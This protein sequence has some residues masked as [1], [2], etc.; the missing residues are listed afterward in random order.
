MGSKYRDTCYET[1]TDALQVM[2]DYCGVSIGGSS[3]N[4]TFAAYCKPNGTALTIHTGTLNNPNDVTAAFSITP[5]FPTCTYT[6]PNNS[7]I[8][9]EDAVQTAWLVIG[10]WVVAWGIRKIID[11]LRPNS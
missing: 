11:S 5:T 7:T 9:P 2:A 8:T 6:P 1:S 4:A 3:T 10:V